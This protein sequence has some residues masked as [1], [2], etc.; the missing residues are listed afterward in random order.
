MIGKRTLR[1]VA[2]VVL[3]IACFG[4]AASSALAYP[5]AAISPKPAV[6]PPG[7]KTTVT[8]TGFAPNEAVD[9]Y[10]DTT[11]EVLASADVLGDFSVKLTVP[12]S[13]TPG[14]HWI[15][16]IGRTSGLSAQHALTVRASWPMLGFGVTHR[17]FNSSENLLDTGNVGSLD[18]AWSFQ[19]GGPIDSS[20]VVVNGVVYFGSED[21]DVY[22]VKASTGALK[23]SSSTGSAVKTSP[24]VAGGTV[25]T[26]TTNPTTYALYAGTGTVRWAAPSALDATAPIVSK[27]VAYF[28]YGAGYTAAFQTTGG[29]RWA[30]P[31]NP[32]HDAPMLADGSLFVHTADSGGGGSLLALNPAD[33]STRWTA[34][35]GPMTN[36]PSPVAATNGLVLVPSSTHAACSPTCLDSFTASAGAERWAAGSEIGCCGGYQSSAAIAYGDAFVGTGGTVFAISTTD[37]SKVWSTSNASDPSEVSPP[38]VANGVVYVGTLNGTLEALDASTGATLWTSFLGGGVSGAPVVVNGMVFVGAQDGRLYAF[39]LP[40]GSR[41]VARPAPSALR[42]DRSLTAR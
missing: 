1:G 24:A 18:E 30:Q 42:P 33:A 6:R 35:T 34:F 22:A 39:K 9:M 31:M 29:L 14:K 8:G 13:A 7:T 27:G 41:P 28:G 36:F 19:S 40:G 12:A 2:C 3:G 32:V 17:S 23:W 26:G 15:T 25:F 21:G 38:S 10:F 20:P 5:P 11:D 16:A 37:G 4:M